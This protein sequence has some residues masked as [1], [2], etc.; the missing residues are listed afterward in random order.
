MTP[1]GVKACTDGGGGEGDGRGGWSGEA[2]VMSVGR[3]QAGAAAPRSWTI[4]GPPDAVR[5]AA[6]QESLD[7]FAP[8]M[9]LGSSAS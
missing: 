1:T 3:A 4:G 8:V 9:R 7:D 2:P 5:R 6:R